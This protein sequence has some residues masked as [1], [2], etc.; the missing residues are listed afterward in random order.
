MGLI[1]KEDLVEVVRVEEGES[2]A[3]TGRLTEPRLR[4]LAAWWALPAR[5]KTGDIPRDVLGLA[6]AL[7]TSPGLVRRAQRDPRVAE[8]VR[9]NTQ[10]AAIYGMPDVLDV[11][12][13]IAAAREHKDCG[14]AARYVAEVAGAIK[15]GQSISTTT[16]VVNP[17]AF[18][19]DSDEEFLDRLKRAKESGLLGEG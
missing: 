12:L 10:L 9:K 5:C 8:Q 4:A 13:Q 7:G 11:Q 2:G 14:K 3:V 6:S 16:N 18:E 17:I 15:S 1:G 19:A